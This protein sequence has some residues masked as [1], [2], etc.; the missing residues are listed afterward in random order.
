VYRRESKK[1]TDLRAICVTCGHTY[2]WHDRDAMRSRQRTDPGIERPCYREVGGA[3]CRCGGFRDSGELAMAAAASAGRQR[4]NRIFM[5]GLLTLLLVV[6]GLALLYAYRS[7]TPSIPS[8]A[9]TQAIQDVQSGNIQ[10]VAVVGNRATLTFRDGV[11]KEQTT[12]PEQ[13]QLLSKA[14]GDYNSAHPESP[15]RLVY[16]ASDT[17]ISTVGSIFLSLLPVLLIGA[18]FYYMMRTRERS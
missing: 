16:E 3:A 2:E 8:V 11:R 17:P 15:V 14:I 12:L 7:Q 18:F 5:N 13:D 9:L 4:P 1:M 10:A 6:M